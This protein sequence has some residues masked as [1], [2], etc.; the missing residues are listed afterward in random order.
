MTELIQTHD[1]ELMLLTLPCTRL[2]PSSQSLSN[3]DLWS[4]RSRLQDAPCFL[5]SVPTMYSYL[6]W[7]A[8]DMAN[9]KGRGSDLY[10]WHGACFKT[11]SRVWAFRRIKILTRHLPRLPAIKKF[12][13]MTVPDGCDPIWQKQAICTQ[14]INP[15]F[16]IQ[17]VWFR[18]E[19][20]LNGYFQCNNNDKAIWWI[21]HS[22]ARHYFYWL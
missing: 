20:V 14:I 18:D 15:H 3:H 2:F 7:E 19:S 16:R 12:L 5:Q 17:M 6:C 4:K 8:Q 1:R 10:T 22:L 21:P 11:K 9:R 13:K